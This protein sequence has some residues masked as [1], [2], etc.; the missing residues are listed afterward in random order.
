[1][2]ITQALIMAAGQATRMR[3]LTDSLP[4]PL[5]EVQGK[6]LLT[7]IIDHLL[8]E[9]VT[10]IIINGY[11]AI[12]PL[13]AY[14]D[15]I[16]DVHPHCEFILS[17]EAELL[18]TGGAAVKALPYLDNAHPFFMINGD[19]F[20]VNPPAGRSLQDLTAAWNADDHD[21][22]LLL[23]PCESM[24]MTTPVGD[25]DLYDDGRAVR[26]LK[27]SGSHMFA[28]V[29]VCMPSIIQ[30]YAQEKFSFLTIMDACQAAGRLGGLTHRGQWYHISTPQD[31]RDVNDANL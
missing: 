12:A 3:P 26:S 17:A 8:V 10:K 2:T 23:Q 6:P 29:R 24:A 1:M 5:L 27:Q 16:R 19:A 25:Y 11:H 21:L 15:H 13:K 28:G 18:E 22:L 31:L 20:W 9:G 4:K 30:P 7:H 14:I